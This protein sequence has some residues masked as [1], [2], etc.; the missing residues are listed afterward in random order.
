MSTSPVNHPRWGKSYS[1]S[2]VV[3]PCVSTALFSDRRATWL[4][5]RPFAYLPV[6]NACEPRTKLA[7]CAEDVFDVVVM[8][9]GAGDREL[10]AAMAD[11]QARFDAILSSA[12]SREA[13]ICD[14]TY[15]LTRRI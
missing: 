4:A 13:G 9:D 10:S 6:W 3:K 5:W 2:Y 14:L 15:F 1:F 8:V 11:V 12:T 7:R